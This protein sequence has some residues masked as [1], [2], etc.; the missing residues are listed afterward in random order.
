MS[1]ASV[2]I[3]V[4]LL[5]C[6][7]AGF[8]RVLRGPS[9]SDRMLSAQLLGTTAVAVTVVLARVQDMP[10]LFDVALVLALLAAVKLVA[11]IALSARREG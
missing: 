10:A 7:L 8:W 9:H 11:F 2:A 5:A 6:L 1:S 3:L 4:I